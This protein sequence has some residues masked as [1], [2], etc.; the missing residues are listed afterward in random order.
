MKNRRN[1]GQWL[2]AYCIRKN[3]LGRTIR[4]CEDQGDADSVY[5]ER[6]FLFKR[7]RVG[8]YL[9]HFLRSDTDRA[10]HDHPWSFVTIILSGG[11]WEHL[12]GGQCVWRRP[13]TVLFRRAT[14]RHYVQ[15]EVDR[16]SGVLTEMRAELD[17]LTEVTGRVYPMTTPDELYRIPVV[18]LCIVGPKWR[19]WGFWLPEG[20]IEWRKAFTRWGCKP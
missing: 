10:L 17:K 20:W 13:G 14:H 19:E 2:L 11:Y 8:I 15:L 4:G 6:Y 9:H 3:L 16:L 12:E 18:T 5:M 7:E 1:I